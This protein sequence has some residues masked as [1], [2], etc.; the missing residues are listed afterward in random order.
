MK[1][2]SK[3]IISTLLTLVMCLTLIPV[4]VAAETTEYT[5][6]AEHIAIKYTASS[7]GV[8]TPL[9]SFEDAY[10]DPGR[11]YILSLP[12][13]AVVTSCFVPD[14]D[15]CDLHYFWAFDNTH[16]STE[17]FTEELEFGEDVGDFINDEFVNIYNTQPESDPYY[18][19]GD[20]I[21]VTGTIPTDN[22]KGFVICCMQADDP[23][24]TTCIFVQIFDQ[25]VSGVPQSV[26]D[27]I[28]KIKALGTITLESGDAIAEAR[29]AYDQ[30][31]AE[32]KAM[33]SA[34]MLQTLTDAETTYAAL[35]EADRIEKEK[36][37]ADKAAADAVIEKINA[38]GE[39]TL[40]SG[41]AIAAAREAY[42]ALT[43]DQKALISADIL[44]TL[45]DA[46]MAYAIAV[47]KSSPIYEYYKD[48]NF[49]SVSYEADGKVKYLVDIDTQDASF[50]SWGALT[51][52]PRYVVTVPEGVE[53]VWVT[54]P[55]RVKDGLKLTGNQ[56]IVS[57]KGDH[58]E[59]KW[60][61]GY[62]YYTV[63]YNVRNNDDGS[64]SVGVS[65]E[66]YLQQ[67]RAL[68]VKSG[69]WGDPLECFELVV[70]TPTD[71][72]PAE[73]V[74]D[75]IEALPSV[76]EVKLEDKDAIEAARAAYEALTD[77]QKA[78]VTDE[79]LAAL[80]AVE[81][82]LADLIAKTPV[83]TYRLNDEVKTAELTEIGTW[84]PT[85]K[86]PNSKVYLASLPYGA[87]VE[88]YA[89]GNY[90][91]LSPMV[92]GLD[93]YNVNTTEAL[94]DS[95]N[96]VQDEEFIG[97]GL[98]DSNAYERIVLKKLDDA[99]GTM[100]LIPTSNVTG[101][102]LR[103]S[104][105]S[106]IKIAPLIIVQI[107]TIPAGATEAVVDVMTQIRALGAITIESGDAIAA[108]RTAYDQ[109][110]DEEKSM[111]SEKLLKAL[112]AAESTYAK[113]VAD[114]AAADA[115]IEKINAIGEVTL[116]SG[117]AITAAREAYDAL[118]NDQKSLIPA[119]TVKVLTDAEEAYIIAVEMSS[120]VYEYYK[121]Y[122][123]A[124]VSYEADGKVKYLVDI[125]TQEA[126]FTSWG[127]KITIPRYIV[128]VPEGVENVWV[129]YPARVKADLRLTGNERMV[130]YKADNGDDKWPASYGYRVVPWT[131]RDNDDGSL[132]VGVSAEGYLQQKRA[133][134]VTYGEWGDPLE[135]FELVVGTPTDIF[136]ADAVMDMIEALP[137]VDEV[138]L[139]DKEAIEAARAAYE[140]LTDEQKAD[141]TDEALATLE[142]VEKALADLVA[143]L[144][145]GEK[146]IKVAGADRYATA[147]AIAAEAFPEAP[148]EIVVVTGENF[149][150]ALAA[151][152]Y[153]GAKNAAVVLTANA[154]LPSDIKTLLTETWGGQVKSATIIGGTVS[155]KVRADLKACGIE[156]ISDTL[157][158]GAD[159]Y[160]T[161]ELICK[162]GLDNGLFN[163]DTII[164]AKGSKAA[165]ALSISSWSYAYKLPIL[166]TADDKSMTEETQKLVKE[167]DNAIILGGCTT[168]DK[169]V[170]LGIDAANITNLTG[171]TR[172]ETAVLISDFFMTNFGGNASGTVF[173][174]G[175]D[176]NFPDALA[177]GMLAGKSVSP[178]ILVSADSDSEASY[179]YAD[180]TVKG[181]GAKLYALGAA[182]YDNTVIRKLEKGIG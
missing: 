157:T 28:A 20:Y 2:L 139:E 37:A 18:W 166:L 26:K 45:T 52:I 81:K 156:I 86:Y 34:G 121:D 24:D 111:I 151:N 165:D 71:I 96:F 32:E 73:T 170:A 61:A 9:E 63:P 119:E 68:V 77:E 36:Q 129:T 19:F 142:A 78:D 38:I 110:T 51:T 147:A 21:S 47:E 13:G 135:C 44:K 148:E 163:T 153:A 114:K 136:P 1:K 23:Y 108:A 98:T 46:E 54:Y 14:D 106:E 53:T 164:L 159:R 107:S 3:R 75:M 134:V 123:F 176:K 72:F 59:D 105:L 6:S 103:I 94:T 173:A 169:L 88:S 62:G 93:E 117:D 155:Q 92:Y 4:S 83:L 82:A 48:Y 162:E 80:E 146:I 39:V 29:A 69:D 181:M 130:S 7:E 112:E 122:D 115:V 16:D 55:A 102:G 56:Q 118:T 131:L 127:E 12:E 8:L 145:S 161:A 17:Y 74:M 30:L 154:E 89:V 120:P 15:Q 41:D 177:G 50:Y 171:A 126:T 116:E 167:F 67:K 31:T 158:K 91:G 99:E 180:A 65:A 40:E 160:A 101:Y 172:Y 35:V 182:A 125:D 150:D 85:S 84:T 175:A 58:G 104:G 76:D 87:D 124:S 97:I 133:L 42:D 27:V 113:L 152:A 64:L 10:E 57:Y 140:A 95:N 132:S 144:R 149:P 5:A 66:S 33:I 178:I 49:T 141:V 143:E 22:V 90:S 60:P 100:A 43:A 11:A 138:K 137:S 25:S 128:T 79:A 168:A 174:M 70:G 109:L 179:Q